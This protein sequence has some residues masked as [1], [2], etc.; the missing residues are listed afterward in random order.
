M[1]KYILLLLFF[2]PAHLYSLELSCRFE[3]V[4]KDGLTQQGFFLMKKGKFRY[5]YLDENLF[6]IIIKDNKY[7][8][9]PNNQKDSFRTLNENTELID[10]LLSV[11][12]DFQNINEVYERGEYTYLIEKSSNE[13]IKRI[14]IKSKEIN[15]SIN[16]LN[17]KFKDIHDKYFMHFPLRP[18]VPQ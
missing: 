13:F 6:T 2:L 5:E 14:A 10:E 9:V 1:K 4:Y 16:F 15:M 11:L 7:Y 17:C 12:S 8:L 3:E 18:Y